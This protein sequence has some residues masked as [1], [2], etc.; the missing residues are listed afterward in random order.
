MMVQASDPRKK[1]SRA[2]N[3]FLSCICLSCFLLFS[4]FFLLFLT[5]GTAGAALAADVTNPAEVTGLMATRT[6]DDVNLAWNAVTTDAAGNPETPSYYRVYRGE[7]KDFVPDKTAGTNR[8]G[9][10]A[11]TSFTDTGAAAAGNDYFYLVTA[12]DAAGNESASKASTITTLP[13]LSG[14]WTDTTIELNWTPA[15]PA[16]QIAGYRVYYGK[17]SRSY[18][19]VKDVGMAASTSLMGLDLWVNWYSAVTVLDVNGNES[20]FSNEHVDAVAGR[21]KVKAHDGDYL[22]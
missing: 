7:A 11:T 8:I 4:L 5:M 17:K 10:P 1:Y 16:D 2:G 20:G 3:F 15:Q 21:V 19:F 12:V 6:G 18:D 14:Y 22:C 13:V 9:A